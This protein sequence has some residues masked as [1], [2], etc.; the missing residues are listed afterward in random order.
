MIFGLVSLAVIYIIWLLL[1]RGLLWKLILFF[2]GWWGLYLLLR[3]Q[4]W[5]ITSVI[6]IGGIGYGWAAIIPSI[7]CFMALLSTKDI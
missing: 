6:T 7:I 3:M 4:A 1:V 2:A 5:A